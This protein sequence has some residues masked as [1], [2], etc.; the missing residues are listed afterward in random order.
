MLVDLPLFAFRFA[1][2]YHLEFIRKPPFV[3]KAQRTITR[4]LFYKDIVVLGVTCTYKQCQCR[5]LWS[6]IIRQ[7]G[8]FESLQSLIWRLNTFHSRSFLSLQVEYKRT[9]H[10]QKVCS[11]QSQ[12]HVKMQVMKHPHHYYFLSIILF[13]LLVRQRKSDICCF[14]LHLIPYQKI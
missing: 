11:N 6:F 8:A 4:Y 13:S 2:E 1:S 14:T 12:Q 5:I 3:R 7:T 9:L 10:L